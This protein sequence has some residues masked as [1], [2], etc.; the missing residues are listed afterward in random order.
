MLPGQQATPNHAFRECW[1][2]DSSGIVIEEGLAV[3]CHA[4]DQAVVERPLHHV[5]VLP[6]ALEQEQA[7]VPVVVADRGA[8][9]VV[10]LQVR[11]LV[12]LA[13]ALEAAGRADAAG[14]VQLAG[15]QVLPDP[16]AR[17]AHF[18]VARQRGDV[19]HPRIH[20]R[21][22]D[23]VADRLGL[24]DDL[25]LRLV[26]GQAAGIRSLAR[27]KRTGTALVEQELREAQI[28]FVPRHAVQ[29]DESH[30]GDLMT[31]P[32][33]ALAGTERLDEKIGPADRDVQER[34][35]ARRHVVRDR[36]FEEV[37]EVV[38][39]VAVVALA[40]PAFRPRPY[41]RI[42][43][44]D[45]ARR[46]QVAVRLLRRGD[47]GDEVVDVGVE[48]R[49]GVHVERVGRAL[50][51]FVHVR[52][53]ERVARRPLVRE[54]LASKRLRGAHEQIHAARELAL[55]ERRGNARRPVRLHAR[56]P[57]H[58]VELHARERDRL[59]R[60]VGPCRLGGLALSGHRRGRRQCEHRPDAGGSGFGHE[61]HR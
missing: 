10:G 38:E 51:H 53:V 42:L 28:L 49:V 45:R 8:G 46:V 56:R 55:L 34:G 6:I 3:E 7:L 20:V 31:R 30:L 19:S 37:P 61:S 40:R 27:R 36:G 39:L 25:R 48:L 29:A 26:V 24:I 44:V 41:M 18:L 60:I 1:P 5:D 15:N 54:L 59:D 35:L 57:E 13:E 14:Q 9:L 2:F 32:D 23:R 50:D 11:Q 33:R 47:L 43:R 21:G 16:L 58:V 4:R 52:V 17:L 22:A 12:G